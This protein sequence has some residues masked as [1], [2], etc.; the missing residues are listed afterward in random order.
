MGAG[1][2]DLALKRE[3]VFS[4]SARF[5]ATPILFDI[6]NEKAAQAV[7]SGAGSIYN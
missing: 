3:I 6:H 7:E 2:I 1:M 5:A 4:P